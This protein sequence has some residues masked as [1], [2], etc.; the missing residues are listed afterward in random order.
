MACLLG[1]TLQGWQ[2]FV[3]QTLC[4]VVFEDATSEKTLLTAGIK[5]ADAL[6]ALLDSDPENLFTVLTA[7]ELNPTLKIIAR[8]EV[9]S[10]ESRILRAGA[11]S[12]I[13][14]YASAGKRVADKIL[15]YTKKT[16]QPTLEQIQND[17]SGQWC[18]VSAE[19]GLASHSVE[20]AE[21]ILKKK[22][23]GVRRV[24]ID[25][26]LPD[27]HFIVEIDDELLV[28]TITDSNFSGPQV[29]EQK[30]I[31]LVDDNPVIRQLYTRLFQKAGYNIKTAER[32]Q[33]GL[34]LI[35]QELPDAA[36]IDF[37]LPDISGLEVCKQLRS[38]RRADAIKLVLFTADEQ[39][40]TK[41]KALQAGVETVV[42][43]SPEA[44]EII[45][46][47]EQTLN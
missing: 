45:A 43:K 6:L 27:A 29:I 19:S 33:E 11:D 21:K 12:V 38:N 26:L 2:V 42:L 7:R 25:I 14:P 23:V 17:E 16:V 40:E 41:T 15:D 4:L 3:C 20:A 5:K 35:L 13:S 44:S 10:S 1:S 34:D 47:I 37:K 39:E 22:I 8:T 24:G 46:I 18:G 32:G 31:I 28:S 9:A 36:V 30:K